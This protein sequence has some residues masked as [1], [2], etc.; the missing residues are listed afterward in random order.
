V[1]DEEDVKDACLVNIGPFT[2]VPAL[3]V[4]FQQQL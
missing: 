4:V 3:I 2:L 1:L